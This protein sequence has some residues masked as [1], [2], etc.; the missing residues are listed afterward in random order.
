MHPLFRLQIAIGILA[1]DLKCNG[2]DTGFLSVQRKVKIREALPLDEF[3]EILSGIGG[4]AEDDRRMMALMLLTGMR[5]GEILGLRW[6]DIRLD[7]GLI[8]VQRNVTYAGNQPHVGTPKTSSGER[9]IPI[10]GILAEY[11]QP[12]QQEGFIL[13]GEKP[14][15]EMSYKRH[16]PYRQTDQPS[17]CHCSCFPT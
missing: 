2:L 16:V 14:I 5:R 12:F 4:L 10:N 3:K 15:T 13:G 1:V 17:Q 11:L 6:E 9:M 7:E 8:Y